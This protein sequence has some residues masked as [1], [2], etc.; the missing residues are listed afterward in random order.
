MANIVLK[1]RMLVVLIMT[2]L[3]LSVSAQQYDLKALGLDKPLQQPQVQ[4]I[5][6]DFSQKEGLPATLEL[7]YQYD[8]QQGYL[9]DDWPEK[10]EH[11][12]WPDKNTGVTWRA[13]LNHPRSEYS[14]SYK[15]KVPL[16]EGARCILCMQNAGNPDHPKHQHLRVF[17]L[18]LNG[19]DYFLQPPLSPYMP[20]HFVLI[21]KAHTPMSVSTAVLQ[22]GMAFLDLLPEYTVCSNS[23]IENAGA[24]VIGHH[25]F[26]VYHQFVPP[27]AEAQPVSELTSDVGGVRVDILNY[28]SIVFHLTAIESSILAVSADSLIREWKQRSPKNTVNY[29][30]RKHDGKYHM[31]LFPRDVS[32][33][34]PIEFTEIKPELIGFIDMG[35]Q[36]L[37]ADPA[38]SADEPLFRKRLQTPDYMVKTIHAGLQSVNPIRGWS[39]EQVAALLKAAG[40]P[41]IA[42]SRR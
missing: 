24:T 14:R 7:L 30:L 19:T 8:T 9:S 6:A 11:F 33:I 38:D 27:V 34:A 42:H 28:P 1:F 29:I 25:H 41:L 37:L 18:S 13:D 22:K 32:L 26:Q 40:T 10:I 4:S 36:F 3:S 12:A 17:E 15:K 2:M 20:L 21:Q 16:P 31:W 35:G 39:T 5:L 23:D